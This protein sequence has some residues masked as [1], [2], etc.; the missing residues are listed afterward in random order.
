MAFIKNYGHWPIGVPMTPARVAEAGTEH[1]KNR[2]L[3]M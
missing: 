2:K 3:K 1:D